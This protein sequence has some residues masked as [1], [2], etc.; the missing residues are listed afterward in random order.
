MLLHSTPQTSKTIVEQQRRDYGQHIATVYE[1]PRTS[2]LAATSASTL[3]VSHRLT[4]FV[5][6][7]AGR[8]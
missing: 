6:G 3:P 8:P 4:R 2:R 1:A 5:A 7:N